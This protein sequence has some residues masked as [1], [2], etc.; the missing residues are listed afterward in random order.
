MTRKRSIL[1][2][3]NRWTS[4]PNTAFRYLRFEF[5]MH[6][7]WIRLKQLNSIHYAN[8]TNRNRDRYRP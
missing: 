7:Q 1:N 2:R 4:K 5:S 6:S 3:V 8:R